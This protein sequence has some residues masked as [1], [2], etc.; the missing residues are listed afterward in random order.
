VGDFLTNRVDEEALLAFVNRALLQDRANRE[1]AIEHAKLVARYETLTPR[2]REVLP[3]LVK[4]LLN[5]QAAFDL[6]ITGRVSSSFRSPTHRV[7]QWPLC[8]VIERSL[9]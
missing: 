7:F 1:E 6:G 8:P 5:K 3:R 2:E 4:G 9:A